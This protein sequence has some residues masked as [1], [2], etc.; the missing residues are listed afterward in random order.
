MER[1]SLENIT[2]CNRRIVSSV[3]ACANIGIVVYY[4]DLTPAFK[5][6][7]SRRKDE[8]EILSALG[9]IAYVI[10]KRKSRIATRTMFGEY[11]RSCKERYYLEH[12]GDVD[13]WRRNLYE[14]FNEIHIKQE[15]EKINKSSAIYEIISSS[16]ATLLKGFAEEYL[17]YAQQRIKEEREQGDN[18]EINPE[19]SILPDELNT[20]KARQWLN[21]AINGGLLNNDYS[22]T[23]KVKTKPQKAL[24][25]EILSEKIGLEYKY[26]PFETLW[27]VSGLA[28]KRYK[29]REE[30]GRVKG[31]DIIEEVFRD[32]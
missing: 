20:D 18:V 1:T 9:I 24:L 6:V 26:K 31:G 32:K 25:A 2:I 3:E 8:R 15:K 4:Y 27:N 14:E 7:N 29:S 16:D 17:Q 13:A 30:T 10:A 23:S 19:P 12:M 28:K 11:Y 21:V 5:V 22:T